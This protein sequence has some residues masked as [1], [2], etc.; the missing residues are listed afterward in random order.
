[1]ESRFNGEKGSSVTKSFHQRETRWRL[2]RLS[3]KTCLNSITELL[4]GQ[5]RLWLPTERRSGKAKLELLHNNIYPSLQK[6]GPLQ[7]AFNRTSSSNSRAT[8]KISTA[9]K[10]C[11]SA[12]SIELSLMPGGLGRTEDRE[13]PSGRSSRVSEANRR[14]RKMMIESTEAEGDHHRVEAATLRAGNR[15]STKKR[16]TP[17]DKANAE[18]RRARAKPARDKNKNR[19]AGPQAQVA[20]WGGSWPAYLQPASSRLFG[21]RQKG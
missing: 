9:Q 14:H 18:G 15:T 1:M 2:A 11:I 6:Q 16:T 4:N 21:K 10:N 12:D 5:A 17:Q 3:T 19:E 8:R 20:C 13:K 7:S